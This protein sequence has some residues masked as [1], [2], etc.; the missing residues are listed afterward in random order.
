M[1]HIAKAKVKIN[2]SNKD[3]LIKALSHFGTITENDIIYAYR[4]GSTYTTDNGKYD[5]VLTAKDNPNH[6]IGYK[7]NA[8]GSYTPYYD[9]YSHLGTWIDSVKGRVEDRYIAYHYEYEL[10]EEGFNVSITENSAGELELE[11]AEA[12]W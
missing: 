5:L 12:A 4:G 11:A 6:R 8:N 2:L 7:K 3:F 9:S 10:S 1:S